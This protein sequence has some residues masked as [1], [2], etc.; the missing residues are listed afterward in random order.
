MGYLVF[1]STFAGLLVV[2]AEQQDLLA[3]RTARVASVAFEF[4]AGFDK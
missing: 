3:D 2:F 4:V 1:G